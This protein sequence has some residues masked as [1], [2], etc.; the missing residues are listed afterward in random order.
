MMRV[1][2]I[3]FKEKSFQDSGWKAFWT[4][5][6]KVLVFLKQGYPVTHS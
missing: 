6:T 4:S 2:F 5:V 1:D 3:A